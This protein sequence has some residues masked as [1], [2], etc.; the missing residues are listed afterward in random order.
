MEVCSEEDLPV[1][2]ALY[3]VIHSALVGQICFVSCQC[4]NDVG[5]GLPLQFLHPV[6]R[7]CECILEGRERIEN[8]EWTNKGLLQPNSRH[9]TLRVF[10]DVM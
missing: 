9:V 6:L 2:A 8:K 5:A 4:D 3:L 1:R 10:A 7:A